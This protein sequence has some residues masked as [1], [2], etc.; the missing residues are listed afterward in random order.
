MLRSTLPLRSYR[1]LT[2][3]RRLLTLNIGRRAWRAAGHDQ[4]HGAAQ[5]IRDLL[6]DLERGYTPRQAVRRANVRRI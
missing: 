4:R 1:R 5:A 2:P 3:P 6:R